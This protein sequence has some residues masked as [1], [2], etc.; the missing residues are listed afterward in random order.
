VP[1]AIAG[2]FCDHGLEHGAGLIGWMHPPVHR[3]LGW[4]SKPSPC[5]RRLNLAAENQLRASTWSSK[6]WCRGAS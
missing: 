2:A 4:A 6:R 5:G 3:L 1:A